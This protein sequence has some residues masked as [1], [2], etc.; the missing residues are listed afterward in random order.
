MTGNRHKVDEVAS[1]FSGI[2]EIEH[3]DR[4]L[5]EIRDEDVGTV[6]RQKAEAAWDLI[7]RPLIV[8]DTGFF[9]AALNGFPGATA[10]YV[11]KTIGN[12]GILKLME[13]QVDRSAYFETAIA[14]ASEEGVRVFT[15]RIDGTV[16]G[17]PRGE[18][19]F[20]YDP[21]FSYD[22]RALAEMPMAE[23]SLVSHRGR[24]LAAF[25]DWFVSGI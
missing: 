21:I 2:A 1:F 20:G 4:E 22:G 15:G 10:A 19:G 5:P 8:D 24:A 9:I 17:T 3:L 23:K 18:G 13:D 16:L 6:A 11:M 14:Y 12:P 7:G 25:R